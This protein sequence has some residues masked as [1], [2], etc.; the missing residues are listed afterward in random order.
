MSSAPAG[1]PTK[2]GSPPRTHQH[3]SV[4][5]NVPARHSNVSAGGSAAE[6]VGLSFQRHGRHGGCPVSITGPTRLERDLIG[7][8]EVP[9]GA[10][11]G[12]QTLRAVDNYQITG[13]L[14]RQFPSFITAFA[15][16]KKSCALANH[17]LGGL[18]KKIMVAIV[19][20]CDELIE[21]PDQYE[22]KEPEKADIMRNLRY[23]FVV[24]M[25]QGGAG[26]STNMNANEVIANRALEIMGKKKGDYQFCHPNDHVNKAQSTN[27]TYPTS[28]K[29][30]IHHMHKHLVKSMEQLRQSFLNK[31][32]EFCSVVKMGRTQL[33]D[34]VPMTLGQEFNGYA[35]TIGYDLEEVTKGVDRFCF[36]NL[37]GTAIGTKI[38]ADPRF[39]ETA[40]EELKRV[41]GLPIQLAPDL[42]EASSSVGAMLFFSG[43]LR[44]V[45][46]KISKICNDLRLLASGP[47]CGFNEIHLPDMAPGSSIMPGKV[48][49]VI[50][51]VMSMCSFQVI[52]MDNTVVMASEAGQ[53]ELNVFEPVI[54]HSIFM[55]MQVLSKGMD[56]L[57]LRCVDGIGANEDRCRELVHNSIGIVTSLLPTIG[58]KNASLVAKT[59]L[60]ENRAVGEVVVEKGFLNKSQVDEILQPE[61]MCGISS[62]HMRRQHATESLH[63]PDVR[64]R[65]HHSPSMPPK[66]SN[67]GDAGATFPVMPALQLAG[68]ASSPREAASQNVTPASSLQPPDAKRRKM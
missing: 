53:L 35:T 26:T 13:M 28:A 23:S 37:G 60:K 11:Y 25:V 65:S 5:H 32:E 68:S 43:I 47:R 21:D 38:A 1:Q 58:Y 45:A 18:D 50:P 29:I 41:T 12:V 34:A 2:P 52:G 40:V 8:R 56:T 30:A 57:R 22:E 46:V 62:P 14:L 67:S 33:Q 64:R 4:D 20:A 49:P 48:N 3:L 10:Y 24:D 51:E 36:C 9:V 39:S 19:Q 61:K 42:I 31:A 66:T 17:R 6:S 44:R 63:S 59:A 54:I 55:M 16:V 7:E 27:D 15:Q